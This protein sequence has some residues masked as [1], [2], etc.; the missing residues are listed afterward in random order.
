MLP[1][2]TPAAPERRS[3]YMWN[4]M[5]GKPALSPR[6]WE[7]F[8]EQRNGETCISGWLRIWVSHRKRDSEEAFEQLTP[9]NAGLGRH[10]NGP[11]DSSFRFVPE[12]LF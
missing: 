10:P 9:W 7:T 2:D 11:L 1:H 5:Q 3:S 8:P 4:P 6:L 12:L